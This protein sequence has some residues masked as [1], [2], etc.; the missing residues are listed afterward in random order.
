MGGST[1]ATPVPDSADNSM[2]GSTPMSVN[3]GPSSARANAKR[4]TPAKGEKDSKTGRRKIKIEFIDDDSRRHITFSKRKAGIMKKAYELATLT[5]TQVLLLVVSQTGLV[6]TF[7]TPKLEA[8][9]KEP[10]GRNLIQECLNAPDPVK[11]SAGG[12]NMPGPSSMPIMK[13][14][15]VDNEEE[16]DEDEDED[17]DAIGMDPSRADAGFT[18]Q[19]IGATPVGDGPVFPHATAP[20]FNPGWGAQ[21]PGAV[22]SSKRV[23]GVE[24]SPVAALKRRRT[25]PNLSVSMPGMWMGPSPELP[26]QYYHPNAMMPMSSM[27]D[28]LMQSMPMLFGQPTITSEQLATSPSSGTGPN[29]PTIPTNTTPSTAAGTST[30]P[31]AA[32]SSHDTSKTT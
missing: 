27:N 32:S 29:T 26:A 31:N 8:V 4:R 23:D 28:N 9:V 3:M 17:E 20:L 24:P 13:E 5:G 21:T 11:P 18:A 12:A 10:E 1:P 14:D 16:G 19:A 25:Q 30:S 22:G 2:T 7:T 15:Y 6:Y